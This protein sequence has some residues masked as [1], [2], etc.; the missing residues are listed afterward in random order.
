MSCTF[1]LSIHSFHTKIITTIHRT[2][3]SCFIEYT[4]QSMRIITLLAINL[5]FSVLFWLFSYSSL[6]SL[7]LLLLPPSPLSYINFVSLS[8]TKRMNKYNWLSNQETKFLPLSLQLNLCIFLRFICM[9]CIAICCHSC[10]C[11]L[12]MC[13]LLDSRAG[14][15]WNYTCNRTEY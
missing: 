4:L 2:R 13:V 15:M 11:I 7:L 14:W 10:C 5:M 9:I 1:F 8:W 3:S 12:N 6:I